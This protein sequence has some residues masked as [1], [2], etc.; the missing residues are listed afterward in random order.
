M[1]EMVERVARAVFAA[2]GGRDY[3][4]APMRGMYDKMAR[5]AIEAMREPSDSMITYADSHVRADSDNMQCP[6]FYRAMIDAAL[7]PKRE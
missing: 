1:D 4:K 2:S 5:A 7:T 3:D 6:D